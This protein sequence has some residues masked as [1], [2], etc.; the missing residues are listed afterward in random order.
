[1]LQEAAQSGSVITVRGTPCVWELH[2]VALLTLQTNHSFSP[3]PPL[4]VTQGSDVRAAF[5]AA[6]GRVTKRRRE[7]EEAGSSK[8][9]RLQ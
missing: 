2:L 7:A 6:L 8:H 1:M 9:Q 5:G 4:L 3:P